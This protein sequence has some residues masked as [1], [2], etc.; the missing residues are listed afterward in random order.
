MVENLST[1]GNVDIHAHVLPGVDDGPDDLAES[2]A[3]ARAA[4]EAGTRTIV[5]TPHLRSD[6]PD[7]HPHELADR[8]QHLRTAIEA[9]GIPIGLVCGAETSLIWALE[10]DDR[11][12]TLATY[13]QRGADLLIETPVTNTPGLDRMLFELRAKGRRVTLAHPERSSHFQRDSSIL[14]NLFDQDILLQIN[15]SSLLDD[16]RRQ[17]HG[18][19]ARWLCTEGLAHVLASDGHRA[20]T[21]RPVTNLALASGTA[22][23]LI[24]AERASWMMRAA[25]AAILEGIDLPDAPAIAPPHRRDRL[26]RRR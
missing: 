25:P 22:A 19:L 20:T 8:C 1:S 14:R 16:A 9:D 24:G 11:D 21:W 2:L 7:V 13:G 4:A 5:S 10:A 18:K 12:L 15:A 6:F 23:A 17:P 26:L 3:M